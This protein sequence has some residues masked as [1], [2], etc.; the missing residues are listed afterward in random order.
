MDSKDYLFVYGTL[1]KGYD[2]PVR[3]QVS[4]G[5]YWIGQAKVKALL[6]DLGTFPGAVK[7]SGLNEILGDVFE[8]TDPKSVFQVLDRYEGYL[9]NDPEK[10][11][12]I[13][14][15][16]DVQMNSGNKLSVWIYWCNL[17]LQ[18]KPVIKN[19]DYLRYLKKKTG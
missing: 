16:T 4:S 17:D 9:E 11:E 7:T 6:Y 5:L 13:R 14:V 18:G 19:K 3:D 8:V 10:S 12:Y 2:S 15:K 1:R